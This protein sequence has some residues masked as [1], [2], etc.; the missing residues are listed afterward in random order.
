MDDY[1]WTFPSIVDPERGLS[2]S[3][4]V[5]YQPFYLLLDVEGNLVGRSLGSGSGNWGALLG[6]LPDEESRLGDGRGG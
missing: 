2:R 6:R 1:G 4:G 3:F 5:A